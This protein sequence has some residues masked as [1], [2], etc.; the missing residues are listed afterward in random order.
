MR[1]PLALVTFAVLLMAT[2]FT[3]AVMPSKSD[4]TPEIKKVVI[5][6]TKS[7]HGL[8]VALPP[9]TKTLP[10]AVLPLP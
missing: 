5:G 4:A 6:D 1:R 10:K 7:I 8:L 9:G 3:K 2:L